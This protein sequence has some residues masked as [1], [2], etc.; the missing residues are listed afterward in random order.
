MPSAFTQMLIRLLSRSDFSA[1]LRGSKFT[2]MSYRE[3]TWKALC[4]KD[5]KNWCWMWY[6]LFGC[7]LQHV[8]LWSLIAVTPT[9]PP[10]V[11]SALPCPV[12]ASI[13][14]ILLISSVVA[15]DCSQQ[16]TSDSQGPWESWLLFL[17]VI[18]CTSHGSWRWRAG[19][20]CM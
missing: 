13:I 7:P 14:V 15:T 2:D 17:I 11:Y 8:G 5:Q 1:I 3:I 19:M 18:K 10:W 4:Q 6:Q 16:H 9:S 12:W 20:E